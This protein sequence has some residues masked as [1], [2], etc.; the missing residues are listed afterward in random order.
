MLRG[1]IIFEMSYV[2]FESG[3]TSMHFPLMNEKSK[4]PKGEMLIMVGKNSVLG[5]GV[6]YKPSNTPGCVTRAD[7]YS[8]VSMYDDEN[9]FI[10]TKPK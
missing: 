3:M 7:R 9:S 1:P 6:N 5:V 8:S 2:F 4:N 10:R